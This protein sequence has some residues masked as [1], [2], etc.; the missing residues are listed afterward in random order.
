MEWPKGKGWNVTAGFAG[1]AAIAG[2]VFLILDQ[3]FKA[4]MPDCSPGQTGSNC[5]FATFL[6]TAYSVAGALVVWPVAAFFVSRFLLKR[7][8]R[9]AAQ[10]EKQ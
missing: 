1:G 6:Q 5:G 4:T 7:A 3:I 9:G 2:L 10:A 8:G